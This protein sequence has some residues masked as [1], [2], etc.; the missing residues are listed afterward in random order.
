MRRLLA[1]SRQAPSARP[2]RDLLERARGRDPQPRR[3]REPAPYRR[4]QHR[5]GPGVPADRGRD[6]RAHRRLRSPGALAQL[7]PRPG[8]TGRLHSGRRAH[9]PDPAADAS[10]AGPRARDGKDLARPHPPVVQPLS[11]RRLRSRGHFAADLDHREKRVAAAPD[12][13]RDHRDRRH[14]RLRA[15]AAIDRDAEGHGLRHFTG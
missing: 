1:L 15:R 2:H 12:R 10:A 5:D 3:H 7:P 6:E 14:L 13:F 4:F 8:L 9:R 11:S